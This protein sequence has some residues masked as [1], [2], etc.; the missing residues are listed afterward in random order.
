MSKHFSGML[1]TWVFI[2]SKTKIQTETKQN[3]KGKDT[4][5]VCDPHSLPGHS[6]FMSTAL[7]GDGSAA[8]ELELLLQTM[9]VPAGA[10]RG[11]ET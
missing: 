4:V 11:L 5:F 2:H 6:S 8:V 9:G 10:G 7:A 1:A 3:R